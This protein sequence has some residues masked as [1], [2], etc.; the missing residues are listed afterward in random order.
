MS[1]PSVQQAPVYTPVASSMPQQTAYIQQGRCGNCGVT[2]NP[3]PQTQLN[4]GDSGQYQMSAQGNTQ[5]SGGTLQSS[6]QFSQA[7]GQSYVGGQEGQQ[8]VET[9]QAHSSQQSMLEAS[10]LPAQEAPPAKADTAKTG[11][12][13]MAFLSPFNKSERE[14]RARNAAQANTVIHEQSEQSQA[15][16][17]LADQ[18]SADQAQA[19]QTSS[20]QV[21]GGAGSGQSGQL[22]LSE[23]TQSGQAQ[24]FDAPAAHQDV[25]QHASASAGEQLLSHSSEQSVRTAGQSQASSVPQQAFAGLSTKKMH[26]AL[27]E[28]DHKISELTM[29]TVDQVGLAYKQTSALAAQQRAFLQER[30]AL[31]EEACAYCGHFEAAK[32]PVSCSGANVQ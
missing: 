9:E 8:Q 29:S 26:V 3:Y 32:Q 15:D 10:E 24:Q 5:S 27:A 12:D 17:T 25:K 7:S 11:F 13:F 19:G 23:Y 6:H 4:Q 22:S 20:G 2:L 21:S 28:M 1:F 16:L 18:A 30:G 14:E 31:P